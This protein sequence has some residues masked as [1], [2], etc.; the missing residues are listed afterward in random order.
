MSPAL[1]VHG[2]DD[3][4]TASTSGTALAQHISAAEMLLVPGQRDCPHLESAEA[5]DAVLEFLAAD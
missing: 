2:A 3:P 4:V 1:V 5:M